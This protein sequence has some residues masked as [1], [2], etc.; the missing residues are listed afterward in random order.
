[1]RISV[2]QIN[3]ISPISLK[4]AVCYTL[5]L[6]ATIA[7]S[8]TPPGDFVLTRVHLDGTHVAFGGEREVDR[9]GIRTQE[10]A[11]T[12]NMRYGTNVRTALQLAVSHEGGRTFI[13]GCSSELAF[14]PRAF[15]R[16]PLQP[17][18]NLRINVEGFDPN[19][20]RGTLQLSQR[21][22]PGWLWAANLAVEEKIGGTHRRDYLLY[23]GLRKNIASSA[24]AIGG[25]I[26]GGWADRG[27]AGES[28]LLAGPSLV[29]H[30]GSDYALR[31]NA[32]WG[33][34]AQSPRKEIALAIALYQH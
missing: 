23:S 17:V 22:A 16:L 32:L 29:W 4:M 8:E 9:S 1:M 11:P 18:V 3:I 28:E 12:I 30:I 34:T 15:A 14:V 7:R 13:D 31:A 5:L 27:R 2:H 20:L 19:S 24:L 6:S 21:F 33:L 25:E 10:F 26:K